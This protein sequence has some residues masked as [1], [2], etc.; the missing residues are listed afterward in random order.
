MTRDPITTTSTPPEAGA[1]RRP[2]RPEAASLVQGLEALRGRVDLVEA[3]AIERAASASTGETPERERALQQK[4]AELEETLGRAQ[5][6]ARRRDQEWKAAIE[7][8]EGDRKLLAEAWERLERERVD[9]A[10]APAAAPRPYAPRP[11]PTPAPAAA[12]ATVTT[13]ADEAVA[14]AILQ[15]FQALRGDVRSHGGGRRPRR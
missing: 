8:L 12:R 11:A 7:Q 5:A 14:H 10:G 15:Q 2:A 3:L 4:V 1:R 6:E 9:A 13:E